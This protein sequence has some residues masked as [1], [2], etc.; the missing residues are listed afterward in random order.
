M[1]AI[2]TIR[3]AFIEVADFGLVFRVVGRPVLQAAAEALIEPFLA[4]QSAVFRAVAPGS[5]SPHSN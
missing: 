2:F 5:V 3:S 4:A 1:N